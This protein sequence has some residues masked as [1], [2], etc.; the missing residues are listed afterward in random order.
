MTAVRGS[1]RPQLPWKRGTRIQPITGEFLARLI[2]RAR[3]LAEDAEWNSVR[4]EWLLA[5]ARA[6]AA[7]DHIRMIRM[8][9]SE[10]VFF[11]SKTQK[12]HLSGARKKALEA[13]NSGLDKL[14]KKI[15]RY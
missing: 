10:G 13:W 7:L 11:F 8:F 4:K 9:K 1:L 3:N 2:D 6:H 14:R 15:L 5:F 12:G